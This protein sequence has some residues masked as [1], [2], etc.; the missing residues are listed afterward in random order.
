VAQRAASANASAT[1][2]LQSAGTATATKFDTGTLVAISLVITGLITALSA[3]FS[4]LF[5]LPNAEIPFAIIL[6]LLAIS[7]PSVVVAWLK[8]RRRNIGPILDANGWAVNA[9]ARMNVPFGASLTKVATLPPGSQ[10]DLF[11]PYAEK[12]QMWPIP[13]LLIIIVGLGAAWYFGKLDKQLPAQMRSVTIMGTN[14]PAYIP[15]VPTNSVPPLTGT[16]TVASGTNAA[17]GK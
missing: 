8:L 5:D 17:A 4:K 9:Q 6:V 11:D 2:G 14:A 10:R 13:V 15:P 3:I 12:K 16:N 1:A 7:T